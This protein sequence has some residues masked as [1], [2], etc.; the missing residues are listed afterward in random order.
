M[1]LLLFVLQLIVFCWKNVLYDALLSVYNT[2][3][4]DYTS[5]LVV[6]VAAYVLWV[7]LLQMT[8]ITNSARN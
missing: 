8:G 7:G 3:L 2:G 4:N 5:P 6:G 1:Y